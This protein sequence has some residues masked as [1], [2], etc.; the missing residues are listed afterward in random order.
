MKYDLILFDA[1]GTLF[2][3]DTAE[4]EAFQKTF[5]EFGINENLVMLHREY[6]KINKSIWQDFQDKKISAEALRT[7]RFRIFAEKFELNIDP[8]EISPVYLNNL[9][10]GT[11]LLSGA[12]EI[13]QYFSGKCEIALATN[14][15]SDVQRPRFSSSGL[16]EY[17][18]HIFISEEIGHPKP[19]KEYFE[20]IFNKLP[21]KNSSIIVGDNFSS[22]IMGGNNFGID[23][24]WFNPDN[25]QN[26]TEIEPTYEISNLLELKEVFS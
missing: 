15:L 13:V 10:K 21:Y 6:E 22:D 26:Y 1:D 2:D 19:E 9:A 20:H 11:D 23:T 14:G 18:E 4:K 16:A 7:E 8:Q 3:F 5:I 24:C 17:F 12:T 25:L